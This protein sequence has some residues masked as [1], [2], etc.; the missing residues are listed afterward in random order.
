[1]RDCFRDGVLWLTRLCR[2][3]V[4]PE[5]DT[6]IMEINIGKSLKWKSTQGWNVIG[7]QGTVVVSLSFP[8]CIRNLHKNKNG[9]LKS[10]KTFSARNS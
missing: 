1:M 5:S 7:F 2:H 3:G 4:L 8:V 9:N 6:V 10:N